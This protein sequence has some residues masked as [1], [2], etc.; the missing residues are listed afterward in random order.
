MTG[1]SRNNK[2]TS[3][4]WKPNTKAC[5]SNTASAALLMTDEEHQISKRIKENNDGLHIQKQ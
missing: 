2:R 3:F 4:E 1:A 5:I